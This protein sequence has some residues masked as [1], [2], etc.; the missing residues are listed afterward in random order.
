MSNVHKFD[1]IHCQVLKVSGADK[2]EQAVDVTTNV[3]ALVNSVKREKAAG[4]GG[5]GTLDVTLTMV[6]G[7]DVTLTG[8]H[9]LFVWVSDDAQGEGVASTWVPDTIA[10]STGTVL[11][12]HTA[13]KILTVQTDVNGVAVLTITDAEY[14]T[15]GAGYFCVQ[16]P[17]NGA[18]LVLQIETG[19]YA[20]S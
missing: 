7:N 14:A 9:N 18:A 6:D 10:A 15:L 5:A 1:E 4:T 19:D 17:L 2:I 3:K 13:N 12:S 16:N 20:T 8:V 11:F